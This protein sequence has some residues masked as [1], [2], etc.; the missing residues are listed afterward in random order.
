MGIPHWVDKVGGVSG[1][2]DVA[3]L[4]ASKVYSTMSCIDRSTFAPDRADSKRLKEN[5]GQSDSLNSPT[6]SSVL[7]CR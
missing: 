2:Q 7:L 5:H 6:H 1:T 3:R 4:G